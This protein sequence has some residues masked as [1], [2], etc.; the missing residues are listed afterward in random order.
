MG[1]RCWRVVIAAD[2]SEIALAIAPLFQ[3]SEVIFMSP[4]ASTP[5]LSEEGDYIYRN[6]PS[7]A[8]EAVNMATHI[9]NR[10]GINDE[11][12][13]AGHAMVIGRED[14]VILP[15]AHRLCHRPWQDHADANST[16]ICHGPARG[17][18]EAE[19]KH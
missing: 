14:Q 7:D 9:Y 16:V 17:K 11:V 6:F 12:Q 19:K 8:L 1:G 2:S 13:H 3:E 5:K 4:S 15:K 10:A 18:A